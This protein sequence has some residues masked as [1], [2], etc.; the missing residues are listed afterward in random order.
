MTIN[1]L[2]TYFFG[3][4]IFRVT[5]I[6]LSSARPAFL[7]MLQVLLLY[8]MIWS[9]VF[10][11]TQLDS[12]FMLTNIE[13]ALGYQTSTG[14]PECKLIHNMRLCLTSLGFIFTFFI[15]LF[16]ASTGAFSITVD[17]L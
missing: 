13:N 1:T 2:I 16:V 5:T 12:I 8:E 14:E 4:T 17:I 7:Q 9:V 6:D 10:I 3:F 15:L 11:V